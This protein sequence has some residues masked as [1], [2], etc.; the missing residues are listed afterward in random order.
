[1]SAFMRRLQN[2]YRRVN[3]ATVLRVQIGL[4]ENEAEGLVQMQS[5]RVAH[6][7][8]RRGWRAVGGQRGAANTEV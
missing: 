3:R 4:T 7:M 5:L 1:M 2:A 8:L 6:K